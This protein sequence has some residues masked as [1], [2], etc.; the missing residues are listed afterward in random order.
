MILHTFNMGDCEDP[1]LYAAFPI[2]EWQ[3]TE[4]GKWVMKNCAE[5]P[6][7]NIDVDPLSIGYRVVITGNLTP[8]AATF[9]KLKYQ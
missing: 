5:P 7:F 8:E 4:Q 2:S 3:E 6:T 1:Y 9:F